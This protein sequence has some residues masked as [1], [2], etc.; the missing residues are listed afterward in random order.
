MSCELNVTP[1]TPSTFL[2]HAK[3]DP[4]VKY[5]NSIL[6]Y[7]AL[8]AQGVKTELKLYEHGKHGFGLGYEG[9]DSAQWP[10]DFIRWLSG[11]YPNLALSL[12]PE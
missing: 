5:Q 1:Q 8:R 2:F 12:N 11:L 10:T 3:D 9:D 4:V 6:M 7:E